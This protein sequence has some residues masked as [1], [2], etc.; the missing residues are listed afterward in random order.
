MRQLPGPEF[1]LRPIKILRGPRKRFGSVEGRDDETIL[2]LVDDPVIRI[3]L[4]IH[5]A[6]VQTERN[7]L[8]WI[9]RELGRHEHHHN[10]PNQIREEAWSTVRGSSP[11]MTALQAA[12][13]PFRQRCASLSIEAVV[14]GTLS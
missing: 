14:L 4:A 2:P 12:A 11:V 10:A 5:E 13:F 1:P 3:L 7:S 8:E 6:M 9:G